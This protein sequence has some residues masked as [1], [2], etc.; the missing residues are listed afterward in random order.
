MNKKILLIDGNWLAFKSFFAGYYGNQL[1]NSKGDMTFAIHI[2]FN[3]VFKLIKLV[4]PSNIYFAFDFGS[5]TNR[6]Q[7][8]PDYKKGR[9][10]PPE[11][12]F[13]Q[14][15]IIKKILSL[16]G[17]FWSQDSEF[18][19]DDL[20]ASMQ[21][22][23]RNSE[24]ETEIFIFSSDQ[25]LLQLVDKKT[26]IINKIKNN[27]INAINLEN[28]H[29]NFGINPEQIVD[30][31][32][33]AGD[34]SDNIKIIEGL[35]AK[36]AIKLL[37]KY[38]NVDNILENLDKISTK[39][40]KQ[41]EEKRGKILFFKDFIRLNDGAKFNFDIFENLNIKICP[42]LLNILNELELKKVSDALIELSKKEI[43]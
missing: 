2:F 36:G 40:S 14:I 17:F 23:I 11:S 31:K 27:S 19:A 35:G 4:E 37:E 29:Q 16:S 3:T 28:F 12:L 42:D 39:L 10:K 41:I 8:Y 43:N 1:I 6:H 9:Q 21:K 5:T 32:V 30:F 15:D 7:S 26:T 34:S 38:K 13:L 33:L 25:D 18:E 22:I 20:I 24:P